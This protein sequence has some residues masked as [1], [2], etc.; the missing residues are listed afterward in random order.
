LMFAGL[1][2]QDRDAEFAGM[3]KDLV[4]IEMEAHGGT[5]IEIARGDDGKWATV[6]DS[7]YNRR[8]SVNTP[9]EITGP[10]AGHD[11]MKTSADDTGTKA[12]GTINNCA[13]GITP[14]GTW[15]MAEENFHGYFWGPDAAADSD[16]P[17]EAMYARYGVPGGWYAWG[18][19]YD[20]FDTAKEPNEP[21]RFGWM[22]EVDP[23]NPDAAPIKRTALGRT[24]HE[25]AH[26]AVNPDG[27]IVVFMGDD[28]R[29]DYVYRFVT[30]AAYD[31]ANP[32]PN[33][34]DAG[35]LSVARYDADG[36]V[37]WLPLTFGQGELTEANGFDSQGDVLI[38]TRR[39]ADLLGAT[40]MDRPED[41]EP[42]PERGTVYVML[43][44]NTRRKA[45]DENAANPRPDNA[46]GHIIEMTAP[47]GDFAADVMDWNIL[48]KCGDPSV[49]EVGAT[50]SSATTKDGWFGM[51]DNCVVDADGRLWIATD[52]NDFEKTGRTDGL[53]ALD[54]EGEARGTSKH[55]YRVPVGAELCGPTFTDSGEMLLLAIQHPGDGG[56]EWPEFGRTSTFEDPSTRWP[57]FADGMPPRPS[58]VV[59]T[60]VGGGK[61]AS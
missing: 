46:F 38:Q 57:D 30:E 34:L 14:W 59:V 26:S 8:I 6:L 25:G 41:V 21:H 44:N 37:H 56:D 53:W 49:E 13:G 15:L 60:K 11:K 20:R 48:V 51:P 1:G 36:K 39:A 28:E 50:F 19:F 3:T 40:P 17:T 55:F 54:T 16:N 4:D 29:F 2:R 22:V 23:K 58:V 42:N 33:I 61:I 47:D 7:P 12:I 24:K 35:T 18:K 27:R 52:G 5:V 9:M 45:G 43:T 32:D 10:A 31:P